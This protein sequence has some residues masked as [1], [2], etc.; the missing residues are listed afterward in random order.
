MTL[1]SWDEQYEIDVEQ[2]DKEHRK[3]FEVINDLH[4]AMSEGKGRE[5]V[6]QSLEDLEEYVD[7]HFS[8]EREFANDCGFAT[9]CTSC[10]KAHQHAHDAFEQQVHDLRVR[11]DDGELTVPIDTMQFVKTWVTEHVG[12]MDQQLG[13]YVN[14]ERDAA[15]LEPMDMDSDLA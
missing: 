2:V 4:E 14:G 13:D 3:L 12:G 8:S 7:Y 5:Q 6:S 1:L 15:D 9:D 10:H 11:H